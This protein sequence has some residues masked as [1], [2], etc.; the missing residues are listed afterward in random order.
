MN[1]AIKK[2]GA[3]LIKRLLDFSMIMI[4]KI[5]QMIGISTLPWTKRVN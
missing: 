3:L 1:Q 2:I 4:H 5:M